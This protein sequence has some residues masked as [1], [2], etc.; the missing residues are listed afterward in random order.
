MIVRGVVAFPIWQSP[1]EL[2]V[3]AFDSVNY[4]AIR[5]KTGTRHWY[6]D[7]RW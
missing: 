7:L 3:V 4:K 2:P 5:E 1:K 6:L